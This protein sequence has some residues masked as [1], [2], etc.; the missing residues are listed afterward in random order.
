MW[1]RA[2]PNPCRAEE[3]D[4]VVR[5]I[6]IATGMTWD[7]THKRLCDRSRELCS[8]PS[9]NWVWGRFL[10]EMGFRKRA[11]PSGV[12]VRAFCGAHPEGVYVVGTGTHAVACADGC[13]LDA[14]DSGDEVVEYFFEKER[15]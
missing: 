4:C 9:V 15:R 7:E 12:T 10:T 1:I 2:N 13:Y 5:A 3:A 6:S 11:A 8:M 14:W